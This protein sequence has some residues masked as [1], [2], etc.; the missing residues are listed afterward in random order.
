MNRGKID[1]AQRADSTLAIKIDT[2]D[3]GNVWVTKHEIADMFQIFVSAVSSN[4]KVIF[5]NNELYHDEV[6]REVNGV[7]FYN[8][9]VV[10]ALAFRCKGPICVRFRQWLANKAKHPMLKEPQPLIIQ[11]GNSSFLS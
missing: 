5:K 10:I 11:I 6:M 3:S 8:L 4:L 1:I 7:T 9:D 2:D